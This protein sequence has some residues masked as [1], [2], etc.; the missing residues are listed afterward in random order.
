MELNPVRGNVKQKTG[1]G[2][3]QYKVYSCVAQTIT[4]FGVG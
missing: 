1:L 2:L 3:L 4:P